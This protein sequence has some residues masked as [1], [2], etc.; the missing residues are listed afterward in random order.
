V[1]GGEQNGLGFLAV[2]GDEADRQCRVGV[3]MVDKGRPEPPKRIQMGT[4]ISVSQNSLLLVLLA[5]H[6][7]SAMMVEALW[8]FM[9]VMRC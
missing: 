9:I 1:C 7:C 2:V 3:D 6:D 5:T 8:L 4:T